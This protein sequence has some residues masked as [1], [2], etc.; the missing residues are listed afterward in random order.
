LVEGK[1]GVT[2]GTETARITRDVFFIRL[3]KNHFEKR[4]LASSCL[5]V[6]SQGTN[7]FPDFREI[8]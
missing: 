8:S 4:L 1:F 6:R 3:S 5:S 7:P 2:D